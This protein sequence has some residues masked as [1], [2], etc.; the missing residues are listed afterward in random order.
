[1]KDKK[2]DAPIPPIHAQE[3]GKGSG[4]PP[5]AP[6]Q[7]IYRQS[8]EEQ[9]VNPEDPGT[10]KDSNA[11][12]DGPNEKGFE[13][14][15]AGGDLDVPGS[16]DDDADERIGSEDEENNYYSLGGDNHENLDEDKDN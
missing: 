11:E 13:D 4:Y 3:N 14:D 16:E 8:R 7:D 12:P 2:E 5:Y 6:E 1:M 10:T 9:N 15:E